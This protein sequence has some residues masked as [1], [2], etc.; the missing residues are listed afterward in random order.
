MSDIADS[1]T[2]YIERADLK[3]EIKS[4]SRKVR[5]NALGKVLRKFKKEFATMG[6]LAIHYVIQPAF[7]HPV[8]QKELESAFKVEER[9]QKKG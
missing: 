3:D 7:E 1:V 6:P 4:R 9:K 5:M 8:R 2:R